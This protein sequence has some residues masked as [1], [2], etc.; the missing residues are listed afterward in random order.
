MW[1]ARHS[2]RSCVSSCSN[3]S[4]A[5][6]GGPLARETKYALAPTQMS[7]ARP[8][9]RLVSPESPAPEVAPD[10]EDFEDIFRRLSPYVARIGIRIL[11]RSDEVEDLVQEVFLDAHRGLGTLRD[12]G[13]IRNWFATVTVRHAT[14]RVRRRRL[15]AFVGF[16]A[17]IE[18][19]LLV[20]AGASPEQLAALASVY[21]VLDRISP[22]ARIAWVLRKVEDE[23]LEKI[24]EICACSR[25]TAHR[26][27]QQA[28]EALAEVFHD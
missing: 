1:V 7:M 28:E 5:R 16:D 24:A 27:L 14:R 18:P 9:L 11:G 12:P 25:A 21:R 3:R 8:Q 4:D 22:E 17:P 13:A 15:L 2:P 26:R 20:D 19:A 10:L 23:P 6:E